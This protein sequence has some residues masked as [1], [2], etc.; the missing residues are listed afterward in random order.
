MEP[1]KLE[2]AFELSVQ[3][4]GIQ[5]AG[6]TGKGIR[7]IIPIVG[8]SFEGP[9]IKGTIVPGGYD[10]QLLR[11]DE[12]AEVEARYVLQTGDGEL[13]TIVNTGLR[14]GPA[15]VMQRMANGEEVHPSEYY[16]RS[17][18]FFET[19]SIKYDWLN[20][21]IFIATGIRKPAA[22]FIQVWKVL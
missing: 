9:G 13:I 18:P 5:E 19:A 15:A 8:G 7:R 1:P 3:V 11:Q 6:K 20:K 12:V 22:V 21:H 2:F 16:F 17:I 10:W 14:Y 4:A